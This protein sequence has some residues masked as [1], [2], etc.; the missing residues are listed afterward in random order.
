LQHG[1]R[2][3][4]ASLSGATNEVKQYKKQ[5]DEAARHVLILKAALDN[6]QSEI[7]DHWC[8]AAEL[9]S[10]LEEI[11]GLKDDLSKGQ[12]TLNHLT[13]HFNTKDKE[14]DICGLHLMATNTKYR[15]ALLKLK[16]KKED[17]GKLSIDLIISRNLVSENAL[18][19]ENIK[20]ELYETA[21]YFMSANEETA[22]LKGM[23]FL[24]E[25]QSTL[26]PDG[27]TMEEPK[28]TYCLNKLKSEYYEHKIDRVQRSQE[29]F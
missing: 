12:H 25:I 19:A 18:F 13:H 29:G 7:N 17:I 28:N 22:I 1:L 21:K 10:S 23:S 8:V 11:S 24:T 26:V 5:Y 14:Y 3:A 16:A 20:E 4:K 15:D 6:A 9:K 27:Q 2:R